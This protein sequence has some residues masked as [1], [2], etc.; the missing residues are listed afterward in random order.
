[1]LIAKGAFPQLHASCRYDPGHLCEKLSTSAAKIVP[2]RPVTFEDLPSP[3]ASV[4]R[5]PAR[6][7]AISPNIPG[8]PTGGVRE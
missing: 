8:T 4:L 2:E 3:R 5:T 7:D 6:R 1:M